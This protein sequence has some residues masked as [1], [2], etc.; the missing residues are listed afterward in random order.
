M[1]RIRQ[2]FRESLDLSIAEAK[3]AMVLF[4][5]IFLILTVTLTASWFFD[6]KAGEVI[7]TEF[8]ETALP[9]KE[10]RKPYFKRDNYPESRKIPVRHFAFDPNQASESDLLTLGI[11]KPQV[12]MI[13][14]YRKKN[15]K[16][17]FKE[18][19]NR[20]YG[21]QPEVYAALEN[22]I[23]LPSRSVTKPGSKPE[24]SAKPEPYQESQKPGFTPRVFSKEIS[25]FDIN[26]ADTT[27]LKMLK[28]IGS[29]LSSRIIKF[30]DMLGGFTGTDQVAETYGVSPE[31]MEEIRKYTFVKAPVNK[32][33][34]NSVSP[35]KFRHPYLKGYLAKTI[36][37]YRKQHGRFNSIADLRNIQTLDE[38]VITKLEPYLEFD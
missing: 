16:F 22:Y 7:I 3:S 4:A 36:I 15:G 8:G 11:A 6:K 29:V 19:L 25:K 9:E 10:E 35:E 27:Q 21:F 24:F 34:I 33:K 23:Q 17:R 2:F 32:I 28:G 12:R 37:N 5:F 38:A 26:T 1:N 20:I 18:D 13:V 31:A 14:N 30:R